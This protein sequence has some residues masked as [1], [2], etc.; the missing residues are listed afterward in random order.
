M[1]SIKL[2]PSECQKSVTLIASVKLLK[3]KAEGRDS[4][5]AMSLVISEGCL[6]AMITAMYSGKKMVTHPMIRR[7]VT[8]QLI[9]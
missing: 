6:K 4:A 7:I 5:P 3:L 8:G 1:V 9:L 2:F